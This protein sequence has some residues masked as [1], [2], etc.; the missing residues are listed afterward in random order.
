MVDRRSIKLEILNLLQNEHLRLTPLDL[1]KVIS[2]KFP[3]TRRR[4]YREIIRSLVSQGELTYTQHFSTTHFEFNYHRTFQVSE[5]IILDPSGIDI[6][7]NAD[8]TVIKLEDGVTFGAGDHPTT[9]MV[10]RG[11]DFIFSK[12]YEN[13]TGIIESA[14]DIGTGNGVLALAAAALGVNRVKAIDIDPAA[15]LQAKKN[16]A[17]N[18]CTQ[19]VHISRHSI[20][21]YANHRFDLVMANLRPPTLNKLFGKMLDVS[22]SHALWILSGFRANEGLKLKNYLPTSMSEVVWEED[23]HDWAAFAVKRE[24]YPG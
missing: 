18:G 15:C 12:N 13:Q 3:D 20:E 23:Q 24:S 10:L 14:L 2:Q 1:E 8:R 5:H 4:E 9:R 7:A 19:T 21:H 22:S 11:L 16:V 6:P 17:L